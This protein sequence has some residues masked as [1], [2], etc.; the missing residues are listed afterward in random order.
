MFT[1]RSSR[2]NNWFGRRL[3]AAREAAKISQEQLA[4]R[5]ELTRLTIARYESGKLRPNFERLEPI[6]AAVSQPLWWF[7]TDQDEKP[8]YSATFEEFCTEVLSRLS[9][10]EERVSHQTVTGMDKLIARENTKDYISGVEEATQRGFAQG[11]DQL[12]ASI[13]EILEERFES[14]PAGLALRLRDIKDPRR[15]RH[16]AKRSATDSDLKKFLES[17]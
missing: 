1:L 2:E 16:L 11:L 12:R 8:K 4:E 14:L 13:L 3:R 17:F 6:A 5:V 15:L 7:F 10:L 9:S